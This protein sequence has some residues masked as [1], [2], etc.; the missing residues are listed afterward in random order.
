M[1]AFPKHSKGFSLTGLIVIMFIIVILMGIAMSSYRYMLDRARL[2]SSV[3]A[4]ETVKLAIEVYSGD[5]S[6][7][8][9]SINFANF[10]D[11]A[12]RPILEASSWNNV[13]KKIYSWESYTVAGDSYTLQAKAL[14]S[15]NTVLTLTPT[16]VTYRGNLLEGEI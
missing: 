16:G 2:V 10:T 6:G 12:G 11:Q 1:E 4:L 9:S 5:Y 13:Q 7:Y 3:V 14:D 15:S 8:P